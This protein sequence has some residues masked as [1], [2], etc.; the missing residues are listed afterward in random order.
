MSE[1]AATIPATGVF[2]GIPNDAYHAS[3]GISKS[4][5][6]K[7]AISP[8]HYKAAYID[9]ERAAPTPAMITGTATHT[10]VLEPD[11]FDQQF[12]V[13]ISVDRR[14]KDG[15][16][17]WAEFEAK[18]AGRTIISAGDHDMIRRMADAVHAHPA[19]RELLSV[20][21]AERSA[22]WTDP[23]TGALCKCRADWLRDDGIVADLKT[24]LSAAPGA[25]S[26]SCASLRYHVQNA[27]YLDGLRLAGVAAEHFAFIA[28]EK[29][30]PYAVAV[31]VLE[32]AAIEL[33]R[34]AY[35]RN[36]DLYAQCTERNV[37]PGYG[38]KVQTLTLP[39]WAFN[40]ES[41]DE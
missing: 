41:F 38:D 40:Q 23:H 4:G 3:A 2:D 5:L 39:A 7:I 28:V 14:T 9:G 10:A 12:I 27:Y 30:P 33:G 29:A 15:K 34:V 19:A 16:A 8:A 6:D 11:L 20:G 18:A 13:G 32:P 17:A 36:L 31:Y 35:R 1:A 24:S 37:W 25:F 26:R 22:Y 21:K